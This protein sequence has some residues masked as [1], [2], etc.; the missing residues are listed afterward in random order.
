MFLLFTTE[1]N[2]QSFFL[3]FYLN[4][5]SFNVFSVQHRTSASWKKKKNSDTVI[6]GELQKEE[7]SHRWQ[8]FRFFWNIL[9]FEHKSQMYTQSLV[10]WQF[11][12]QCCPRDQRLWLFSLGLRLV[13]LHNAFLLD[14]LIHL[15][16][17]TFQMNITITV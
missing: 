11:L 4:Q 6:H 16:Q 15:Y 9:T 7:R 12:V 17:A 8:I 1:R 3:C 10:E 2:N 5:F 13:F 14:F